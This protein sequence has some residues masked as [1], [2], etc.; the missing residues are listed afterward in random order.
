MNRSSSGRLAGASPAAVA[1]VAFAAGVV[2]SACPARYPWPSDP[3]AASQASFA[4]QSQRDPSV[5]AHVN[6]TDLVVHLNQG[7][8]DKTR[9]QWNY[10]SQGSRLLPYD[11]YFALQ[12]ADAT[13]RFHSDDTYL[14]YRYLLQRPSDENPDGL[15]VGFVKDLAADQYALEKIGEERAPSL[16][17]TGQTANEPYVGLTCAACHTA[18][19][20][21]VDAQNRKVGIR[22]DGAGALA[23]FEGFLVALAD[24]MQA[25]LDDPARWAAFEATVRPGVSDAAVKQKLKEEFV[26]ELERRKGFNRRTT[27]TVKGGFAR[28]DA[29]TGILNQ[30]T[31]FVAGEPGNHRPMVNPVSYPHVWDAPWYDWVEWNGLNSNNGLGP[32]GRNVGEVMG[33][34][35]TVD[36]APPG[37]G[38]LGYPSSIRPW[39]LE[40]LEGW[41]KQLQSPPWPEEVWGEVDGDLARDGAAVYRK[42]CLA[43]HARINRQT[44][45]QS[46]PTMP[47]ARCGGRLRGLTIQAVMVD[48]ALVGTDPNYAR[49]ISGR[50]ADSGI[51]EGQST[52]G[53]AGDP[54][55]FGPTMTGVQALK[56]V[57]ASSIARHLDIVLMLSVESIA[58]GRGTQTKPPP[59]KWYGDLPPANPFDAYRAR[60]L[61][62]IWAT[63]PYLHNGSVLTLADLLLPAAQRP[64]VI[65]NGGF[66]YDP[67]KVG[68]QDVNVCPESWNQPGSAWDGTPGGKP[69]FG[70]ENLTAE[71]KAAFPQMTLCQA[72][73]YEVFVD[74]AD[75]ANLGNL[76]SGHEYGTQL[77]DS[78]KKALLE[79]LKTL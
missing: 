71:K 9:R 5:L 50:T 77:S 72:L 69:D 78:D 70:G 66:L 10:T 65:H 61:N 46:A 51:L 49:N 57:V 27:T 45:Q 21:T 8:D 76:A 52:Q 4:M 23:D 29:F 25:T 68:L 40:E 44:H 55:K 73:G 16:D 67:V 30:V 64:K 26:R 42:E 74:P 56:H 36:A 32:L 43:C 37:P 1:V 15:P 28:L 33:S 75:P 62:G 11:W 24:A 13:A 58:D 17:P 63:A 3:A 47:P 20:N 22:I 7:W 34:F 41:M 59:K 60:A 12:N 6:D 53:L 39:G 48:S 19:Y 38:K 18:Q 31:E 54:P 2:L 79:Y 35:A 14:R